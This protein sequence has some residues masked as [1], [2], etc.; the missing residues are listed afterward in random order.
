MN[1][2]FVTY[3][4]TISLHTESTFCMYINLHSVVHDLTYI[5]STIFKILLKKYIRYYLP[6]IT[7]FRRCNSFLQYYGMLPLITGD[8]HATDM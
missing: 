1:L 5:L 8:Y 2:H 7:S 6:S 4:K 3:K